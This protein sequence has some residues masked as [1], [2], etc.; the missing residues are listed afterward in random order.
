M[1]K[2]SPGLRK[3]RLFY[4]FYNILRKRGRANFDTASPMLRPRHY[5][6]LLTSSL[7]FTMPGGMNL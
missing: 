7:P 6:L 3:S 5:F 4:M 2:R 1:T